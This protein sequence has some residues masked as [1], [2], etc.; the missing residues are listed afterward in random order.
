MPRSPRAKWTSSPSAPTIHPGIASRPCGTARR[1]HEPSRPGDSATDSGWHDGGRT[2]AHSGVSMRRDG[3]RS[4]VVAVCRAWPHRVQ[5]D[6]PGAIHRY[7]YVPATLRRRPLR[8]PGVMRLATVEDIERE[9]FA[10]VGR[11]DNQQV[12]RVVSEQIVSRSLE[13]M[14]HWA[15]TDRY[16]GKL[17]HGERHALSLQV[18]Q[19]QA[20]MIDILQ[21]RAMLFEIEV[22]GTL[23]RR[24]MPGDNHTTSRAKT[25]H[26][27]DRDRRLRHLRGLDT[28]TE[29]RGQAG[30]DTEGKIQRD[31]GSLISGFEDLAHESTAHPTI[32]KYILRS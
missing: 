14:S 26:R 20:R 4:G 6:V 7:G 31:G 18:S 22:G 25:V 17:I 30:R 27:D 5:H 13:A 12:E 24:E 16:V 28:G 29:R 8:W 10:A 21:I 11:S 15:E 9:L 32:L 23:T 1:A 2:S 3:V 19:H